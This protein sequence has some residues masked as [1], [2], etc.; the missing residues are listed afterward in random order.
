[1]KSA[2]TGEFWR[3]YGALPVNV[4][5][6][7]RRVFRVWLSNPEFPGLPF[8]ALRGYDGLYSVRIG[9]RWRALGRLKGDTIYW[10]WIG[11]H[12]EYD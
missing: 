3:L 1:M 6:T 12:A 11:P 5:R 10:F 2:T 7:A 4:Q 8:K 9:L